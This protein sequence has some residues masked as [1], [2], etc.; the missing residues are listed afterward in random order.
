MI[1][2]RSSE[3]ASG[4]LVSLVFGLGPLIGGII[5]VAF[6]LAFSMPHPLLTGV[7]SG[8]ALRL[9]AWRPVQLL[10]SSKMGLFTTLFLLSGG[11]LVYHSA[12]SSI[13]RVV[14]R[15]KSSVNVITSSSGLSL[16]AL[17]LQCLLACGSVFLHAYTEGLALGVAARKA[18]GLGRYMVLPASLHGLPRGAA[19]ASCVYGATDSWRGALAAAALTGVAGP[20]AA[21]SAILAKIDY[22]GLDYWMV[23]ACGAL[24]PSFVRVFRR[25]LRLDMRKSIVGLLI[26]IAF[27]SVCLMSNRFICLHTPY[28][29]SAP[30][31]VT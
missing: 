8:I 22:D 17:T 30:E 5:L 2:T 4:F 10:M 11:S 20:S 28:C 9:A 16:S 12:T 3:D 13:L 26:G 21:I 24:I 31:A 23:I 15:K 1:L 25:S 19:V 7:A 27:A 18:Y 6:S 29:N 14:N